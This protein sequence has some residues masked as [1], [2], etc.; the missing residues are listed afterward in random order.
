[1]KHLRIFIVLGLFIIV[2]LI[3]LF[4]LLSNSSKKPPTSTVVENPFAQISSNTTET[5]DAYVKSFYLW[6][7]QVLSK[8]QNFSSSPDFKIQINKWLTPVFVA[9]WDSIVTS[10]DED[11]VLLSQDF[12][13]SWITTIRAQAITTSSADS[14]TILLTL[15]DGTDTH[16]V[17]VHVTRAATGQWQIASVDNPSTN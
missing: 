4:L 3:V 9:N 12:Q 1:M 7:L 14:S 13:D 8:D 16:Q 11:P 15:G 6:Y 2:T 5:P 10:T 17:I